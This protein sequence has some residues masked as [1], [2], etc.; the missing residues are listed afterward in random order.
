MGKV[1]G[2]LRGNDSYLN[3]GQ[4][5]SSCGRQA[6]QSKPGVLYHPEDKDDE[7]LSDAEAL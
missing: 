3:S 4:L 6:L 1:D 2:E 5:G 7:R